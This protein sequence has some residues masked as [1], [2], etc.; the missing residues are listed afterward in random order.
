MRAVALGVTYAGLSK[1]IAVVTAF[2]NTAGAT[3]WPGAGLTLA[4]LLR[5]PRSEWPYYLLA[6]AIA[7]AAAD[8]SLG[9]G[10]SLAAGWAVAN[11]AE[12]LIAA[13]LLRRLVPRVLDLGRR[14][15]LAC[16]ALAAIAIGPFAGALIGTASGALLAGDPWMPRLTRWYVGDAM[17]VLLVA[18]ALLVLWQTGWRRLGRTAGGLLLALTLLTLVAVA[19]WRFTAAAGLP[20]LA[21][22]LLTLI[23]LRSG[24]RG[25]AAGVLIV[26]TI[27][28]AITA[29]G[30]G[31]FADDAGAFQAQPDR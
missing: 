20:F 15:D 16:F 7:E 1:L 5:R 10:V 8:V 3:F 31:P 24:M 13:L 19:P 28:Q 21:L 23:A 25:A 27:V 22:P 26:A 6:V 12:P 11:T 14:V 18:P 29:E 17:G 4:V 30:H 9:F 2:G